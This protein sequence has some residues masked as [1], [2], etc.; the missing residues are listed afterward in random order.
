MPK[1]KHLWPAIWMMPADEVY[2]GWAASGEIDIMEYR[3]QR[4]HTIEGTIHYG[5]EWP[6]IESRGSEEM[7]YP[8]DFSSDYHTFALE[9]E[10]NEIR[11][12]LD[13]ELQ[14]Y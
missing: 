5:G 12:L 3:G 2:G 4:P 11:W 6:N 13:G 7:K 9:W 14:K 8:F 1:G 10:W